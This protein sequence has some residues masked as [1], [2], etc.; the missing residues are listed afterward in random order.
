MSGKAKPAPIAKAIADL[1]SV[2]DAASDEAKR[3]HEIH[4]AR[5]SESIR[6]GDLQSMKAAMDEYQAAFDAAIASGKGSATAK[7][8]SAAGKASGKARRKKNDHAKLKKE[9][10][11]IRKKGF[12][13]SDAMRELFRLDWVSSLALTNSQIYKITA[14]AEGDLTAKNK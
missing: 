14:E 12:E 9:Y 6:I 8:A 4:A 7:R 2:I 5:V 3:A 10:L 1:V 11:K 13:R